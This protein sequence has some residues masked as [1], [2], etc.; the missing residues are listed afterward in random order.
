MPCGFTEGCGPGWSQFQS[1]CIRY[2]LMSALSQKLGA[3]V[4]YLPNPTYKKGEL[5]LRGVIRKY[6]I[7]EAYK[8]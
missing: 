4:V 1:L 6:M 5:C 2:P 3:A 7:L 8:I